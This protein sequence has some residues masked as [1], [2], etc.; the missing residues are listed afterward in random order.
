METHFEFRGWES[1][2]AFVKL[3]ESPEARF[4]SKKI[5]ENNF[6]E[7]LDYYGSPCG[8]FTL[9]VEQVRIGPQTFLDIK[10]RSDATILWLRDDPQKG[11]VMTIRP[12]I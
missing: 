9:T 4:L 5:E 3:C 7:G 12:R 8:E 1:A 10:V 11:V 2:L 6:K